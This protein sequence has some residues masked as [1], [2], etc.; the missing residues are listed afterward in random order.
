MKSNVD[1]GFEWFTDMIMICMM[2]YDFHDELS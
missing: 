2:N 1:L